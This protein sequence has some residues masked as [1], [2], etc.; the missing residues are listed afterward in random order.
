MTNSSQSPVRVTSIAAIAALGLLAAPACADEGGIS[1]WLPGQFG[2]LAAAPSTPGWQAAVVYYH[3]SI[4]AGGNQVFPRG[5]RLEAGLAGKADLMFL[6]STYV[7]PT[8]ILGGQGSFG[9]TG[10][11]GNMGASI[12]GTVTGPLGNTITGSRSETIFGVADLYPMVQ[13]KWNQGV[14]NFMTYAMGD[15]P[16]GSYDVNRIANIGIGH[17]AI[18]AGGGYTYFNPQSGYEFSA[19]TG[20]TYNFRNPDSDYQNGIDWHVD[21]GASKFL[22]KQLLVGAVG[23]YYQQLT[24]DSGS[25]AVLGDF[26]SRVAAAGPQIGY[27]I[28]MGETQGYVNLKGYYEFAAQN[29]PEGWNVWLTFAIS[30]AAEPP[31]NPRPLVR[32]Y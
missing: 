8:P 18:D 11:F 10:A 7:V 2:S 12:S 16:V 23:Y 9:L 15:I 1:F 26:K 3:T 24:G 22:T 28:P 6:N 13:I 19:V 20:F 32:K 4:D 31:T 29:R 30:P 25:G 21:W 14:H 27:I 17:G 5:G